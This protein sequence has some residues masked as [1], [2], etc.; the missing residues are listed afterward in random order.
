MPGET[1]GAVDHRGGPGGLSTARCWFADNTWCPFT[2]IP[3]GGGLD[4]VVG[5][6]DVTHHHLISI[7]WVWS[8]NFIAISSP[9]LYIVVTG[10]PQTLDYYL[11]MD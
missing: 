11:P 2:R 7:D 3:P 9:H 5:S 8:P 1:G 10:S 6:T 4:G